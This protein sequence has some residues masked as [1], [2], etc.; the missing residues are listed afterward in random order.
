MNRP[1]KLATAAGI[2]NQEGRVIT[3][4][5]ASCLHILLCYK[6]AENLSYPCF[7]KSLVHF[8]NEK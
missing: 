5:V 2:S 4:S 6:H 1:A 7:T 3:V 8:I